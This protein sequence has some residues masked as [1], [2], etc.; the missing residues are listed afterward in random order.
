MNILVTGAK[1]FV[2]KNLCAS[3]KNIR[4]GKD[5][6]HPELNIENIFEYDGETKS[7][8]KSRTTEL[9]GWDFDD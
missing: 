5:K 7:I 9:E 2:G 4:D 8:N 1:G 6:T 3:L